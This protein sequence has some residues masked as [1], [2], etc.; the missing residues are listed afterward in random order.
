MY[1]MHMVQVPLALLAFASVSE[2]AAM[3]VA[4]NLQLQIGE[5]IPVGFFQPWC[6]TICIH[7]GNMQILG[8]RC[9][10]LTGRAV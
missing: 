2:A 1:L 4:R 6:D 10:V 5:A 7:N 3:G 9:M 8:L